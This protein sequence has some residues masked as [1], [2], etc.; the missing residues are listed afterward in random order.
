MGKSNMGKKAKIWKVQQLLVA[1]NNQGVN[2]F[3][4][5]VVAGN[6]GVSPKGIP[7]L[8]LKLQDDS[9]KEAIPFRYWTPSVDVAIGAVIT[10]TKA[11]ITSSPEYGVQ[12][13]LS[14]AFPAGTWDDGSAKPATPAGVVIIVTQGTGQ[15]FKAADVNAAKPAAPVAQPAGTPGPA[16]TTWN[17]AIANASVQ[18]GTPAATTLT[19]TMWDDPPAAP[20]A[21]TTDTRG[22]SLAALYAIFV[23]HVKELK[24]APPAVPIVT[25][26]D[27]AVLKKVDALVVKND[28]GLLKELY[29]VFVAHVA[30]IKPILAPAEKETLKYIDGAVK[31]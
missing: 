7:Y 21:T 20:A 18:T 17:N 15:V 19:T 30:Q 23:A 31:S 10:L 24:P 11:Y 8:S 28:F 6:P 2:Q 14:K 22:A 29:A 3:Q 12:L 25:P 16:V 26:A 5:T 1:D 13:N 27:I 4:A 9:T